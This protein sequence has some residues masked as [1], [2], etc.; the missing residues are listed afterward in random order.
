MTRGNYEKHKRAVMETRKLLRKL[1]LCAIAGCNVESEYY[2]CEHHR[3]KINDNARRKR[4]EFKAAGLCYNC[5]GKRAAKPGYVYCHICKNKEKR[6]SKRVRNPKR[7]RIRKI[8]VAIRL[9][10][11]LPK[12]IKEALAAEHRGN[13]MAVQFALEKESRR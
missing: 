2:Y 6:R 3:A 8:K 12:E 9:W 11:E 7:S 4:Q 5:S 10:R 13:N 1:G